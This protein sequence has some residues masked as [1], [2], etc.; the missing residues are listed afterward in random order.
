MAERASF[1]S[2]LIGLWVGDPISSIDALQHKNI[3]LW[4]RVPKRDGADQARQLLL[5]DRRR[6]PAASSV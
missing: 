1:S 3:F 5:P 6:R 4:V 2:A